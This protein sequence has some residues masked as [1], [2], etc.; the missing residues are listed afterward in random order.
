M[1]GGSRSF[2]L[3]IFQVLCGSQIH[4]ATFLELALGVKFK[5][6]LPETCKTYC[7]GSNRDLNPSLWQPYGAFGSQVI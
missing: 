7:E 5:Q 2:R 4:R 6:G 1:A 3:A